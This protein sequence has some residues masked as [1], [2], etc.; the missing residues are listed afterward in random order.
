MPKLSRRRVAHEIVA[1]LVAHPERQAEL[2]KQTAAYLLHHKKANEAHLLLLDI[3]EELQKVQGVVTAEVRSAFGLTS[4]SRDGIAAMLKKVTGA[5]TVELS[6]TV[7]P[8]LIGGVVIRTPEFELD[9]SVKRQLNQ[10]A[11]GIN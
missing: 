11:G 10:L 6:E 9:A 7:E 5:Q 2:L 3:A 1:L 8:E 4:A